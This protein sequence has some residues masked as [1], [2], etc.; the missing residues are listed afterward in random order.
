MLTHL[1]A[2]ELGECSR[3]RNHLKLNEVRTRLTKHMYTANILGQ[4]G[5]CRT[6][7]QSKRIL[8]ILRTF[9]TKAKSTHNRRTSK[10]VMH[11]D[12]AKALRQ[13]LCAYFQNQQPVVFENRREV[14]LLK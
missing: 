13:N 7:D 14:H 1:I 12:V 2:R 4:A 6:A 3:G 11:V 10:S 9:S 5:R 8:T